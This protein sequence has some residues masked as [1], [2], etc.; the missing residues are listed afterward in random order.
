MRAASLADSQKSMGPAAS[1]VRVPQEP[2]I[3]R[4][5]FSE[6][7]VTAKDQPQGG[8]VF[9]RH[10]LSWMLSGVELPPDAP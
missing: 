5:G 8:L 2:I 9:K 1:A 7:V 3:V 10:G 4:R 6:F